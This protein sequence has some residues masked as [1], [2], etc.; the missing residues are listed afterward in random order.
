MEWPT[1]ITVD[2]DG[3]IRELVSHTLNQLFPEV[4]C[5][6]NSASVLDYARKI[7]PELVIMDACLANADSGFQL[8]GEIKR[9]S[10]ATKVFLLT[11]YSD[12]NSLR[13]ALRCGIDGYVV[14]RFAGKELLTAVRYVLRNQFYMSPCLYG[15]S[16]AVAAPA[17]TLLN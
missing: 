8:I 5:V 9:V 3:F 11:G 1:I 17:R 13:R 16:D 15:H 7:H 14:K 6:D 2:D 4:I 10:A 12:L